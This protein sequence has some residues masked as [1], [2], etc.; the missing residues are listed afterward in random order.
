MLSEVISVALRA[1]LEAF[2]LVGSRRDAIPHGTSVTAGAPPDDP[3]RAQVLGQR[4]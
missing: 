3:C 1:D 2:H 4:H